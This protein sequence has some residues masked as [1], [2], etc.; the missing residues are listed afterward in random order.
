MTSLPFFIGASGVMVVLACALLVIPLVRQR[1]QTAPLAAGAVIAI[2]PLV[3]LSLYVLFSNWSWQEQPVAAAP[4]DAAHGTPSVA[5]LLTSLED[6]LRAQPDDLEGWIMLGRSYVVTGRYPDAVEAYARAR[7][8]SG[9]AEVDAI[10]GHAEALVLV[11]QGEISEESGAL[12]ERALAMAPDDRKALWYGGLAASDR[13]DTAQA[14]ERWQRLLSFNPPESMARVLREQLA[15]SD[16]L[17]PGDMTATN[18]ITSAAP[19]SDSG[20]VSAVPGLKVAVSLDPALRSRAPANAPVFILARPVGGGGPP[21]AVIRRQ[22]ADLPLNLVLSDADS[23]MA[24]HKLS[25]HDRVEVIAR[26]ALGGTPSAQPGDLYGS[27]VAVRDSTVSI[28]I[29]KVQ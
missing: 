28:A 24:D 19:A 18:T 1:E 26:I 16:V 22:V 25:N 10:T 2:V 27:L 15:L 11:G 3:T 23:M 9:D 6:R 7:T 21:L 17:A 5:E 4:E 20:A 8:L 29:D 14:R 12:F 13:G